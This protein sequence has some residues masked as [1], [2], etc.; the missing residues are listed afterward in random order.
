MFTFIWID[1]AKVPSV[2]V[3]TVYSVTTWPRS[4]D[5]KDEEEGEE[6]HIIVF[7]AEGTARAKALGQA[8]AWSVGR[9]L[10][11]PIWLEQREQRG[12]RAEGRAGRG[13]GRSLRALWAAGTLAFTLNEMG[14]GEGRG[15]RKVIT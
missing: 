3:A 8:Q 4:R 1:A 7:Q 15:Q 5:P 9:T 11:R 2:G 6:D 12:G 10:R 14:D 13:W